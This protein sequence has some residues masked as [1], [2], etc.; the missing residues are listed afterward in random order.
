MVAII[1]T[2]LQAIEAL[3]G[4]TG[5][6]SDAITKVINLLVQ[7]IPLIE[8]EYE[9]VVPYIQNIIAVLKND[10]ATTAAQ[11][12]QLSE[13]DATADQAFEAAAV[14]AQA[15]DGTS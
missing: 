15:E 7:V 8:K 11:L 3:M 4:V 14:K 13:L 5:L 10:P 2:A 9:D 1:L 12:A 6:T